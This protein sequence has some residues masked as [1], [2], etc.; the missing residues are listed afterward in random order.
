MLATGNSPIERL[1]ST[2]EFAPGFPVEGA[3]HPVEQ[4]PLQQAR[5]EGREAPGLDGL[6]G[7]TGYDLHEQQIFIA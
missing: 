6:V 1:I 4:W 2:H 3:G 5:V 7:V